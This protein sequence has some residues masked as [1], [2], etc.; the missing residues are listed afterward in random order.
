[1]Q[2]KEEEIQEKCLFCQVNLHKSECSCLLEDWYFHFETQGYIC[3]FGI[4][5]AGTCCDKLN[6][7]FMEWDLRY[8]NSVVCNMSEKLKPE[9]FKDSLSVLGY[10]GHKGYDGLIDVLKAKEYEKPHIIKIEAAF[11]KYQSFIAVMH[12]ITKTRTVIEDT[13][14]NK[15]ADK[16]IDWFIKDECTGTIDFRLASDYLHLSC[17][18]SFQYNAHG[19]NKPM[20]KFD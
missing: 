15:Q 14:I 4:H 16:K 8:S 17:P 1:M 5:H 9:L 11:D 7:S 20:P 3:S 6:A 12:N 19:I 13:P 2:I 10:E 18:V